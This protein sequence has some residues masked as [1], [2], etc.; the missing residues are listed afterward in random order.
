[1]GGMGHHY[2]STCHLVY[3]QL[4]YPESSGGGGGVAYLLPPAG[5]SVTFDL[6]LVLETHLLL[7]LRALLLGLEGFRWHREWVVDVAK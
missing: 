3:T 7:L 2:L 6:F 4:R 1:M 5:Q